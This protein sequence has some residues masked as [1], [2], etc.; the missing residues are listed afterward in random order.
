MN[1]NIPSFKK[2]FHLLPVLP[3][4]F[5]IISVTFGVT[6]FCLMDY[7]GFTYTKLLISLIFYPLAVMVILTHTLSMCKSPGYVEKGWSPP[8]TIELSSDR[9]NEFETKSFCK[10]CQNYRPARAHHC[11][12][13]KKCVLKMDHHC[14]WVANCVGFYNQK[15]FYQFLFYATIGDF[16]GFIILVAKLWDLEGDIK[17]SISM[18]NEM[19]SVIELIWAFII[20]IGVVICAILAASMTISIGTLFFFQTKM[21]IFNQTTIENLVYTNP[22]ESPWYY[23]TKMHNF[24]IVMG[25]SFCEWITPSFKEN[26]FNGGF[27]YSKPDGNSITHVERNYMNLNEIENQSDTTKS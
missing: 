16:M 26:P 7:N 2:I 10:K 14:P 22:I 12:I 20:P 25:E 11:K 3:V 9:Q 15:L 6:R 8:S 23:G 4:Y 21:I 19:K 24:K 18:V 1:A 13:C 5:V 17:D 27:N